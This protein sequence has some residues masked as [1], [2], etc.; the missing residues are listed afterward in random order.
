MLS[1]VEVFKILPNGSQWGYW[2]GYRLPLSDACHTVWTPFGTA[3]HW[4]HNTW[5]TKSNEITFLWPERWYV[6]HAFYTNQQTFF[7]CYCD[8]VMPNPTVATD[9]ASLR[10]VDLYVDVVVK[11]DHVVYTKDE[12]VYERAMK[13]NPNLVP[14]RRRVFDELDALATH[15]RD[16]TGPFA[17][18]DEH[19]VRTDWQTLDPHSVDFAAARQQQWGDLF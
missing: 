7:G 16:W 15:A 9:A 11:P 2:R 17:L 10:Y 6:I 14:I 13:Q 5:E 1:P 4:Q 8:I 12:E 3:M 18:I 19:I